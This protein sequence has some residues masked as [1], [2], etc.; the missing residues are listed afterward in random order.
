[1][2]AMTVFAV[3][4]LSIP[5][6]GSLRPTSRSVENAV[7]LGIA[8]DL[9]D[10]VP[11]SFVEKASEYSRYFVLRDFDRKVYVYSVRNYGDAYRIAEFSWDRPFMRCSRFAPD[12]VDKRLVEGGKIRCHDS[13]M[14][15]W[16]RRESVWDYSGKSMGE[17]TGD[18]PEAE[19]EIQDGMLVIKDSF[20]PMSDIERDD[21]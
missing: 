4:A 3:G 16:S 19:Y 10:L 1:M 21:T 18:M 8:I 13:E 14:S 11:G 7:Q 9:D 6:A 5:F 20:W 12:L 15:D 2:V 17:Q